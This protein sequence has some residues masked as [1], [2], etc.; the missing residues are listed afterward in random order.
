MGSSRKRDVDDRAPSP[1][2]DNGSANSNAKTTIASGMKGQIA[3]GD[4]AQADHRLLNW[5]PV[6]HRTGGIA[7][8]PDPTTLTCDFARSQLHRPQDRAQRFE[9]IRVIV[10]L[11]RAYQVIQPLADKLLQWHL[12]LLAPLPQSMIPALCH[13]EQ[14]RFKRQILSL[15]PHP[16]GIRY[17]VVAK[18][19]ACL[20]PPINQSNPVAAD[21]RAR[22]EAGG[23]GSI[24]SSIFSAF[25]SFE[26]LAMIS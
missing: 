1:L 23:Q 3:P 4:I 24:C 16:L 25:P 6:D 21:V 11:A 15:M 8:R 14:D 26:G 13:T 2:G 7:E 12:A 9:V 20:V 18:P 17:I 5:L 19:S 22:P 10:G